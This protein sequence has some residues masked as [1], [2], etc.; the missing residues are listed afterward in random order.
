MYSAHDVTIANMWAYL[1]RILD[2][3][4]WYYIEY[5]SYITISLYFDGKYYIKVSSNGKDL[6]FK[7]NG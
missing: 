1:E 2:L 7:A 5:A 4:P 6:K 3:D